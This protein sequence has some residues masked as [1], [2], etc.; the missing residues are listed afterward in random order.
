MDGI[1]DHNGKQIMLSDSEDDDLPATPQRRIRALVVDTDDHLREIHADMLKR[2]GVETRSVKTGQEALEIIRYDEIY[3]LIL[4]ARHFP[5]I[6]GVQVTKMLRDM[7]YPATIVGV[8][9]RLTESQWEEFF[10]AGL[11]DCIDYET[12]VSAKTLA[13]VVETTPRRQTWKLR[14]V[15]STVY[16]SFLGPRPA[17]GSGSGSS[18]TSRKD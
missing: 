18:S 2:L 6:D 10:S 13:F 17:S 16:Q 9:R 4:L 14:N 8:T 11:D 3:D 7:E 15:Y 5:V 1:T 12:P